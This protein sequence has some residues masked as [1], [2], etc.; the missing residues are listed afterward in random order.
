MEDSIFPTINIEEDFILENYDEV[1][2]E[3]T[4]LVKMGRGFKFDFANKKFIVEAGKVKETTELETIEQWVCLT[5]MTY[6]DKYNVYTNSNFY[7]NIEDLIG[8]KPNAFM[9]AELQREI[10]ESLI[11]HRYIS[12][13]ENFTI[14]YEKRTLTVGFDV[15]L[16]N[17]S[18]LPINQKI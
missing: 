5:L 4:E 8:Q 6:K 13:I 9:L 3:E 12:S 7:C 10:K 15:T 11:K 18:I 1:I 17:N 14:I 16:M 2:V